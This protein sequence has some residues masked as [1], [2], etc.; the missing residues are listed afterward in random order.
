MFG[1]AEAGGRGKAHRRLTAATRRDAAETVAQHLRHPAGDEHQRTVGKRNRGRV[2]HRHLIARYHERRAVGVDGGA[3][4]RVEGEQPIA[5]LKVDGVRAAAEQ[6]DRPDYARADNIG[7]RAGSA[8]LDGRPCGSDDHPGVQDTAGAINE[9]TRAANDRPGIR[10]VAGAI[11]FD[12]EPNSG[13]VDRSGV[14][15]TAGA[16]DSDT[17]IKA[18]SGD[19]DGAGI[20]H[21]AVAIDE[22]SLTTGGSSG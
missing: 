11:D 17:L 4:E 3:G 19:C 13:G 1:D 21:A 16:I 12:A 7:Q 5:A 22:N 10:N 6:I 20:G 2:E 14:G 15:H 18:G 9:H 8:K